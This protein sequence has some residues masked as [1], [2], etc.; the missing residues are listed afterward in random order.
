MAEADGHAD[1]RHH[2]QRRRR[3]D[4]GDHAPA[5]GDHRAGADEGDAR[6]HGFDQPERIDPHALVALVLRQRQHHVAHAGQH[7][8]RTGH[9]H[10]R[11]EARGA[12]LHLALQPD[13]A[14]QQHRERDAPDHRRLCFP[15]VEH[16][17]TSCAD[18]STGAVNAMRRQLKV[19]WAV[20]RSTGHDVPGCRATSR[21]AA[22]RRCR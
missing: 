10:V 6:D 7:G 4:A 17:M 19:R 8:R 18:A 3:G 12:V 15:S 1:H 14:A 11:A 9:Q 22:R 2:Q 20:R 16:G 13:G 21:R 5:V